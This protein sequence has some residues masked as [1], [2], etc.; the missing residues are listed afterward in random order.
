VVEPWLKKKCS[1]CSGIVSFLAS[2][3]KKPDLCVRCSLSA[4]EDL[5]GLL[6]KFLTHDAALKTNCWAPEDK[7][8]FNLRE[9]L[10]SK[11]KGLLGNN[12]YNTASLIDG[13]IKDKAIVQLIFHLAKEQRLDSRP[14]RGGKN[15]EPKSLPPFLQGGAPGL[16]KRSS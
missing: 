4:I 7:K 6:Q 16:G 9:P 1:K 14:K 8:L 10:R 15:I 2:W 5:G 12:K 13:C 3:A 11:V